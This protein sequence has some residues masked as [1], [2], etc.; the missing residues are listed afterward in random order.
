M[1]LPQSLTHALIYCVTKF[2]KQGTDQLCL[3]IHLY[4]KLRP[5]G[6]EREVERQFGGVALEGL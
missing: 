4:Y 6:K 1:L 3:G 2:L 5:F